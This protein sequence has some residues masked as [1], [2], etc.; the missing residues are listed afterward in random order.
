MLGG[1]VSVGGSID[2]LGGSIGGSEGGSGSG[3]TRGE[4]A[5]QVEYRRC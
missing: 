4:S 3:E 5:E 2:D 1:S